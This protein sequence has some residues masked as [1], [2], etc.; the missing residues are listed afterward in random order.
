M[1]AGNADAIP[2]SLKFDTNLRT[3]PVAIPTGFVHPTDFGK[4]V[5]T[6]KTQPV[7]QNKPT[8]LL[9]NNF[10]QTLGKKIMPQASPNAQPNQLNEKKRKKSDQSSATLSDMVYPAKFLAVQGTQTQPMVLDKAANAKILNQLQQQVESQIPGKSARLVASSTLPISPQTPSLIAQAAKPITSEP[11]QI[12][13]TTTKPANKPVQPTTNQAQIKSGAILSDISN[14][15]LIINAQS[16][17]DKDTGKMQISDKASVS[18]SPKTL[19]TNKTAI[20][21]KVISE[22]KNSQ[23]QVTQMPANNSKITITDEKPVTIDKP[24]V[25]ASSRINTSD[26][27]VMT[28][29]PDLPLGAETTISTKPVITSTFSSNQQNGKESTPKTL[30]S[31]NKITADNEQSVVTN[32]P[33]VPDSPKTQL[34]NATFAAPLDQSSHSQQKVLIGQESPAPAE[35]GTTPN[36]ADTDQKDQRGKTELFELPEKNR[37]Q[38]R[39]PSVKSIAQKMNPQRT[40]LSAPQVEN[41]NNLLVDKAS[42]PDKDLGEQVFFGNNVQP[43]I[44]EQS[45]A[46]AAFTKIASNANSG[47]GVSEQIQESIHS[48]LRSG[49]QQIVIRLNPPELGK[50]A[51]KFAEQGDD[52]TGLLQVDKPQTRDQIQQVLPEIIQNLQDCGIAIKKL[53]VVLTNQQEQQTLKD[54]S[55]SAG[56]DGFSGHQSSP[57][58]ESQRN[59]T[60]YSEWLTNVDNVIEFT[61]PQMHLAN[62]SINMLV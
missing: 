61:E 57:N 10:R 11:D 13:S 39:N 7:T 21:S 17:K 48:S 28:D 33:S 51:I 29:E 30:I 20:T 15:T 62:N 46:S 60:V 44:A 54:Q 25:T 37:V 45:P 31:N 26:K 22:Q 49:S 27:P 47:A 32:K 16:E 5:T 43:A 52:I 9:S 8:V 41:H 56:Q 58:P 40:Q 14:K 53:E 4:T 6:D 2:A 59:N 3:K 1:F 24:T 23:E 38:V 19:E 34:S 55:S 50:V 36:K 12:V 42:N 18:E 35:E